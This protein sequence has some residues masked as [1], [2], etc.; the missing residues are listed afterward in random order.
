VH[1]V[2]K[3]DRIR[4]LTD[5]PLPSSGAPVPLVLADE[6]TLVVTYFT[7]KPLTGQA[8]GSGVPPADEAAAFVVFRQCYASHFGPPNDEAFASHPLADR[9]L[10]PYGAFE[11]ESSSWL[12]GFEIRNRAHPRHDPLFFQQLRH[13]VWTFHDSVLE[14]AARSYTALDAQG[15]PDDLLPQMHA[16]L[17]S[18]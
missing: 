7:A 13:W 8:D 12:R 15:G 11:V 1:A 14:C 10:R 2:D 4:E 16:L 6:N 9:G 5:V 17:R 3:R 18:S